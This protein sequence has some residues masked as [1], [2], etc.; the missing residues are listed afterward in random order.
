MS[1]FNSVSCL[2]SLSVFSSIFEAFSFFS[3]L[4]EIESFSFSLG[5]EA[6]SRVFISDF[7]SIFSLLTSIGLSDSF[8]LISSFLSS[9]RTASSCFS[10]RFFALEFSSD[11][12]FSCS[13]SSFKFELFN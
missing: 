4:S 13:V 9:S 7:C 8:K 5:I 1:G 3:F 6:L 2:S 12:S 11:S 10:R